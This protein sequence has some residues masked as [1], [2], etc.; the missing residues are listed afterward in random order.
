MFFLIS[1]WG[2]VFL[3][4]QR[5]NFFWC[6]LPFLAFLQFP[7]RLLIFV[8]FSASVLAGFWAKEVK[9][10]SWFILVFLILLILNFTYFRPQDFQNFDDDDYS[11]SP[12]W[13]YQQREFLTDYLPKTVEEIPQE[14]FKKPL[15]ITGAEIKINLNQADKLIFEAVSGE[16]EEAVIKRFYFPGWQAK[17]NNKPAPIVTNKNG[18]MVLSLSEGESLVEVVFKNTPTR[19]IANQIS[20]L[21]WGIFL[22]FVL[23]GNRI[24]KY[25]KKN[26]D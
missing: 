19:K 3:A 5:S 26:N 21:S 4:H 15:I 12:L 18:F 2:F 17:I 1:F 25:F 14:H 13:E 22:F 6:L 24:V 20:L 9:K 7:W 8:G 11:S 16:K 23:T 10:K